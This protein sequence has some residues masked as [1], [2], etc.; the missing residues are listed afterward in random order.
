MDTTSGMAESEIRVLNAKLPAPAESDQL[1]SPVALA[2]ELQRTMLQ[3]KGQ[4]MTSD[5]KGVDYEAL[6]KSSLFSHY[7]QLSRELV[8]CDVQGLSEEERKAFFI[9]ILHECT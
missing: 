9:S 1:R 3:M 8:D 5:G 7:L 4:F 2:T 6:G